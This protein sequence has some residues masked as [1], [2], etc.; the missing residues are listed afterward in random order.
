MKV[1]KVFYAFFLKLYDSGVY[2]RTVMC[3]IRSRFTF[4]HTD[5]HLF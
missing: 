5:N 3:G 1:R 2:F 4:Y